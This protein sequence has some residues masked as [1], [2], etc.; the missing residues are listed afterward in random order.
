MSNTSLIL[1]PILIAA[2]AVF[3]IGIIEVVA[4]KIEKS[5][6]SS[7]YSPHRLLYYF[8]DQSTIEPSQ[9]ETIR[10][11]Q[12]LNHSVQV[13]HCHTVQVPPSFEW[14][15]TVDLTPFPPPLVPPEL[16]AHVCP[17]CGYENEVDSLFCTQCGTEL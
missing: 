15:D 11:P 4:R 10:T 9:V 17:H 8:R 7:Q 1:I 12:P 16:A 13:P 6:I 2:V 5:Q 14:N 3:I